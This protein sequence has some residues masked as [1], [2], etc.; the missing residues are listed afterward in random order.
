MRGLRHAVCPALGLSLD[1]PTLSEEVKMLVQGANR[2][3]L[4]RS[5]VKLVTRSPAE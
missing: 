1:D 4:V 3:T 2:S 5:L